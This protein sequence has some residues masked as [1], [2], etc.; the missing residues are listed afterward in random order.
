MSHHPPI[1]AAHATSEHYDFAMQTHTK[2][3]LS[4]GYMK[5]QPIGLQHIY[6]KATGEHFAIDRPMTQIKNLIFGTMYI[7]HVGEMKVTNY[8][9]GEVAVIDFKAEGWYGSN[10]HYLEGFTY[11]SQELAN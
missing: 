6:L 1:S 4:V 3:G 10:R 11:D 7:E 2:M 5:A 9:T 8:K